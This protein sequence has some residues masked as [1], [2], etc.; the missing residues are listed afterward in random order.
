MV[1][2]VACC[3]DSPHI[4]PGCTRVMSHREAAE[5]GQCNDCNGGAIEAAP[6]AR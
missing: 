3:D 2:G 5:Q 4:C 6:D 1:T